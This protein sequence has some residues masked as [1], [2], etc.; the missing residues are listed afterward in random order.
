MNT[1]EEQFC[2]YFEIGVSITQWAHVERAVLEVVGACVADTDFNAVAHGFFAI[3][4]VA[5]S[6]ANAGMARDWAAL[7]ARA[8]VAA[9]L[10]NRL[11]HLSVVGYP[12]NTVGRRYSLQPRISTKSGKPSK[13]PKPPSGAMCLSDIVAARFTFFALTASLENYA[14]RLRGQPESFPKSAE[15]PQEPPSIDTMRRQLRELVGDKG[16]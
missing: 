4:I 5:K 3:E 7:A 9:K 15:K 10:R 2:F 14:S 12:S 13:V 11:A 8:K 16:R 6:Q 1:S